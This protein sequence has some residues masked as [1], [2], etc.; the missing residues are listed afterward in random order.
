LITILI[1]IFINIVW[2][3]F[4]DIPGDKGSEKEAEKIV[5][6]GGIYFISNMTLSDK[7]L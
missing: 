7:I 3:C 1:S 2:V 5:G 4:S 6:M